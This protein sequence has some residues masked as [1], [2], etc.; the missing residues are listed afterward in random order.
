MFPNVRTKI[1]N[2]N[3]ILQWEMSIKLI[4]R[5]KLRFF[6]INHQVTKLHL[7]STFDIKASTSSIKILVQLIN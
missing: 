4:P 1:I 7:I 2:N 3:I 5:Y 6:Y